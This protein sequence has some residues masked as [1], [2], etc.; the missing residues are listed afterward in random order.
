MAFNIN[1]P[2][3]QLNQQMFSQPQTA[4]A[5]SN[6]IS[7]M[8]RQFNTQTELKRQPLNRGIGRSAKA[9]LVGQGGYDATR[10]YAPLSQAMHDGAANAQYRTN[11][12]SANE[13]AGLQGLGSMM[14]NQ[15]S[16]DEMMLQQRPQYL[17][18]LSSIFGGVF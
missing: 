4:A 2:F 17:G 7:A 12:Q 5:T 18:L 9:A 6:A 10:Q 11:I 15:L 13:N 16:N 14:Q 3:T 1:S 8:G